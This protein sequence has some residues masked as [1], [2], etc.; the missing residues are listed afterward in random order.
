MGR[1]VGKRGLSPVIATVLLI[2]LA[3]ILAII[4]FLWARTLIN[5]NILKFGE[6][7]ENACEDIF[8]DSEATPT[9][10]KIV[11]RGN[12]PIYGIEFRKIKLGSIITEKTLEEGVVNIGETHSFT[13]TGINKGEEVLIIPIILG[14]QNEKSVS[15]T[16]DERFGIRI[17]VD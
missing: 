6:P 1:K 16:C 10:I 7:I 17:Y 2:S 13:I 4:I 15:H 11:N 9:E 12:V 5:E 8:F 14:E 3:L